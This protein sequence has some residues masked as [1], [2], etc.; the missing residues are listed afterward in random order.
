MPSL[1]SS[2]RS[3]AISL[4]ER[5]RGRSLRLFIVYCIKTNIP[6][7]T[8]YSLTGRLN[9]FD[10]PSCRDGRASDIVYNTNTCIIIF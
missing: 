5:G 10:M 1:T 6:P 8:L 4:Q 3:D 9:T 7:A 2:R